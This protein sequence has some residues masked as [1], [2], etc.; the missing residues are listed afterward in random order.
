MALIE[1][2]AEER[3]GQELSYE[4]KDGEYTVQITAVEPKVSS[5]GKPY[6]RVTL[7]GDYGTDMQF[8]SFNIFDTA[9]GRQDLFSI[10]KAC[11]IDPKRRDVDTDELVDKFLNITLEEGE[12]YNDRR[13]W[14][15]VG[16][17][18]ASSTDEDDDD[19]WD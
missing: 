5:T 10:Y 14:D 18:V 7:R 6:F 13:Q 11:G 12:P 15:V 1:F 17:D 9:F 2:L 4:Y 3:K 19:D 8:Y 16:I